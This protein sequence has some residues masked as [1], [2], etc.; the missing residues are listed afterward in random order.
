M[1]LLSE[2]RYRTTHKFAVLS[3]YPTR[4][5]YRTQLDSYVATQYTQ[6]LPTRTFVG[7]P[8]RGSTELP[9][10]VIVSLF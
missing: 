6:D 5:L 8:G 1:W 4:N 3:Q 9:R 7:K 10:N 2:I